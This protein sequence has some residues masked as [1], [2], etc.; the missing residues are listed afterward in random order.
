MFLCPE[1]SRPRGDWRGPD[2]KAAWPAGQ[3]QTRAMPKGLAAVMAVPCGSARYRIPR[4]PRPRVPARRD[5]QQPGLLRAHGCKGRRK[6]WGATAG[7]G[8]AIR[9][10]RAAKQERPQPAAE[11]DGWRVCPPERNRMAV[12]LE[13]RTFGADRLRRKCQHGLPGGERLR[14]CR[15]GLAAVMAVPCGSARYRIPRNP[16]PR[17]PARRDAQQPGLLRA[18]GCKG[19]RKPWGAT[20]GEGC[21]IREQR[22]AK[23][24]R[25]QPAVKR[26]GLQRPSGKSMDARPLRQQEGRT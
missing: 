24:E 21:A 12:R 2:R 5:A 4:N 6:P 9:E 8:C 18:H 1:S 20:A 11:E 13:R 16:R 15:K 7:E 25:P 3:R 17:V 14:P 19:R 22:A 10:Q 26:R 23:Q